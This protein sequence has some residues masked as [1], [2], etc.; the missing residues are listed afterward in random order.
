MS[1]IRGWTL[2]PLAVAALNMGRLQLEK[3]SRTNSKAA[4]A[5][6]IVADLD[7]ARQPFA[8]ELIDSTYRLISLV[9]DSD[10]Y[11][12]LND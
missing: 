2:Q 4:L 9:R 11:C 10:F 12:E 7:E 8:G 5:D 3:R 1:D 6:A